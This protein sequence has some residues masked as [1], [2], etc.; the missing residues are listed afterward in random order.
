MGSGSCPLKLNCAPV[1]RAGVADTDTDANGAAAGPIGGVGAGP[2]V[3]IEGATGGGA[4][5]GGEAG[6]GPRPVRVAR[7]KFVGAA[8][9]PPTASVADRPAPHTAARRPKLV[10]TAMRGGTVVVSG[11][12]CPAGGVDVAVF[13]HPFS[14]VA[15]PLLEAI[16]AAGG[17]VGPGE[18]LVP[19]LPPAAAKKYAGWLH[20]GP[21]M[22]ELAGGGKVVV[23]LVLPDPALCVGLLPLPPPPNPPRRRPGW[24]WGQG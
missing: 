16:G 14:A 6:S 23:R 15:E 8:M 7:G 21:T 2:V 11:I 17:S 19:V 1:L 5:A 24:G 22:L 10:I 4:P 3:G 9:L 12:E 18:A 20:P 13:E